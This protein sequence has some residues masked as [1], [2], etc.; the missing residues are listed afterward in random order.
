[1]TR[2][3]KTDAL[4]SAEE[5]Y[6]RLRAILHM[7]IETRHPYA[8][9][10]AE[11]GLRPEHIKNYEDLELL[12]T[13]TKYDLLNNYPRGW[14]ACE[15][16]DIVRIHATSGVTGKPTLVAYTADDVRMW[17]E[18]MAWCMSLA[19]VG[20][21]DIVQ[22]SF[23]YGLF[24]GGLG[25]HDGAGILGSMVVPVSGGFT[26][27]QISLMKDLGT[28]VL[29]CTP[30][31]GLRI[32]EGMEEK[33]REGI[34][35]RVGFFGGEAWSDELR[36]TL[37]SCL[38]I[39]ALDLYGLSEA[40]GPGVSV[41]CLEQKGLHISDDFIAETVDPKTLERVGEGEEGELVLTS[42]KKTAFPVIRY[43]TRDLTSLSGA[44]CPCGEPTPR[45]SRVRGRSDDMLIYHGVN[46]FPT[47]V[48]AAVCSVPGL[49]A[50]FQI[51]AWRERGVENMSFVCERAPG[52]GPE[53]CG[54]L[55]RKLAHTLKNFIGVSLPFEILEPGSIPR[56][57]GKAVR[58][59]K[60]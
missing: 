44:P 51:T 7:L 36:A 56:S 47:Q 35:L 25:Y 60:K 32:A 40:M 28:T 39:K 9:R 6:E 30:S 16:R 13:T 53:M 14:F 31:Y 23:G 59:L 41:E 26:D 33:G 18:N 8:G 52:M 37:E 24:T 27:R 19:D 11:R 34:K 4:A 45:M 54:E 12:P 10:M 46:V 20:E 3:K 21:D 43:R 17:G 49:S 42:W 2:L 29:A 1:M 15:G 57:D 38:G 50:N 22:I 58:V 55:E 48:E 5:K